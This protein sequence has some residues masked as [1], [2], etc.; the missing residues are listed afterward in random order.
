M[1]ARAMKRK[2]GSLL[3]GMVALS[4]FCDTAT[5]EDRSLV[6]R[7]SPLV[8]GERHII[9]DGRRVGTVRDDPFRPGEFEVLD[10]TRVR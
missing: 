7:D 4:A 10:S 5:G 9:E 1:S 3:L 2:T 8:S 6:V